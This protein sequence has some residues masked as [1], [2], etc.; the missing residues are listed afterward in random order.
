MS[1]LE[2][3]EELRKHLIRGFI[4]IAI[5]IAIA[6]YFSD[7]ILN[8]ILLGPTRGDFIVYEWLRLDAM[9]LTL[10]S[11]KLPGQF[12]TYFGT[13]M[14]VGA[15]I[16][17]PFFF[18]QL[19][20]FIAP[21]LSDKETSG[22]RGGAFFVSFF[23]FLGI[24][25][26]YFL[27][28]PVALQFFATFTFSAQIRNDFDINEYFSSFTIWLLGSGLVFQLP[29]ISYYLSRIGLLSPK[30]LKKY[31]RHAVVVCLFLAA[32]LTPP[33]PFSQ[34]LMGIPLIGLYQLSILISKLAVKRRNKEI[35]GTEK[36]PE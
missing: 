16:G 12:F 23:F 9:E 25:F 6:F 24:A 13:M 7:F 29:V 35:W 36:V 17:S 2:H 33:D 22:A 1:F 11:R 20:K 10:Q 3:L 14:L 32:I 28:I 30:F 19:W 18:Y 8:Q 26:G 27:L 5:G 34:L 4:G 31:Q 21:A 15:I